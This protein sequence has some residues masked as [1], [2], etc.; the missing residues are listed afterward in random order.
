MPDASASRKRQIQI[1]P[2]TFRGAGGLRA[3]L[4]NGRYPVSRV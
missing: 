1:A 2:R 3:F 4:A